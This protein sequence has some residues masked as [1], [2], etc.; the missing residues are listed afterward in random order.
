MRIPRAGEAP[1]E[2]D[3]LLEMACRVGVGAD[4]EWLAFAHYSDDDGGKT[5]RDYLERA[6]DAGWGGGCFHLAQLLDAR[7][8]R[9]SAVYYWDQAC[10]LGLT[11]VCHDLGD[12]FSRGEGVPPDPERAAKLYAKALH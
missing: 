12:I 11:Q 8:A 6:C 1:V 10:S 2:R 7:D 5:H 4:C 9:T 3:R